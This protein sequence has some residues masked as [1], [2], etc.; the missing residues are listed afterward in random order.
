[1]RII[2]PFRAPRGTGG[3]RSGR[4]GKRAGHIRFRSFCNNDASLRSL[5]FSRYSS[6]PVPGP[7]TSIHRDDEFT[8]NSHGCSFRTGTDA[9]IS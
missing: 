9:N 8:I 5:I 3:I 7:N 1:M 6:L 2:T 4:I